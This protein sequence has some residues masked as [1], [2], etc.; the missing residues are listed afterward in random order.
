M[1]VEFVIFKQKEYRSF[2]NG[3]GMFFFLQPVIDVIKILYVMTENIHFYFSV[4]KFCD[5]IACPES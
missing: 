4:R 1:I 2:R 5:H 3:N